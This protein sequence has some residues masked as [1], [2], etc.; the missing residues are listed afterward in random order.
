VNN[1]KVQF[2]TRKT[3]ATAVDDFSITINA[4]ESVGL[5][6]ESGCG[7]TTTGLAIMRL[8]PGTGKIVSGNIVLE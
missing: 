6:G 1:L 3:F 7:K 4:G 2:A 5:V 8:L